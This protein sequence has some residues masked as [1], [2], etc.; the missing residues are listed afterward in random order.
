MRLPNIF[1]EEMLCTITG[2]VE[3]CAEDPDIKKKISQ[4]HSYKRNICGHASTWSLLHHAQNSDSTTPICEYKVHNDS[5]RVAQPIFSQTEDKLRKTN[6]EYVQRT[7]ADIS[8]FP[9]VLFLFYRLYSL[10]VIF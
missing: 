2:G 4:A 9:S 1:E 8:K 5:T 10:D 6:V 7:N 3:A